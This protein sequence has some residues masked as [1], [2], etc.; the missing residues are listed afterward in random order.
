MKTSATKGGQYFKDA[1]K[2]LEGDCPK[3]SCEWRE[4]V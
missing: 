4:K 2:I 1:I 3:D